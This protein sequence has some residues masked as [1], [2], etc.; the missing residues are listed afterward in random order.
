MIGSVLCRA[1][2]GAG[3]FQ[4]QMDIVPCRACGGSG[5]VI[6]HPGTVTK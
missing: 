4:T 3:Y 2:M 6:K 5:Q 1:C